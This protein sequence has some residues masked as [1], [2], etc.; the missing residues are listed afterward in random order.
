MTKVTFSSDDLPLLKES[1]IW[2]WNRGI[3]EVNANVVFEDVWKEGDDKIFENQLMELA[4]Y[5]LDNHLFDKDYYCS[6]FDDSLGNPYNAKDVQYST[7]CGAGKMIAFS[8]DGGIYPCLRY[9]G[10]SL[11]NH[12]EWPIGN[13]ESGIDM[14]RVRPFMVAVTSIQSDEEC[15]HCDIASGCAYCQGFD[16]DQAETPTNFHRAKYICKM[17]KA[18]V[19]AND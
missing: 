1:V 5:I 7:Y 4:D 13:L 15:L 12:P 18:R 6:L 16:Y 19:R 17:H 9:Y 14:E 8:T 10:H 2:L 11:D 3:K